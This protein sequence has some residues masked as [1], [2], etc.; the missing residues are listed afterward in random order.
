[1]AL[2]KNRAKTNL[3]TNKESIIARVTIC[4][5]MCV[6]KQKLNKFLNYL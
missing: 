5:S 1:M 2:Y 4:Y 3:P 6:Y